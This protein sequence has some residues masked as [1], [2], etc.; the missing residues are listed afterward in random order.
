LG[1]RSH[2]LTS[3]QIID[4]VVGF[5]VDVVNA[6]SSTSEGSVYP[7]GVLVVVS[8]NPLQRSLEPLILLGEEV[9]LVEESVEFCVILG[10][11]VGGRLDR[12]GGRPEYGGNIVDGVE[13]VR[14]DVEECSGGLGWFWSFEDGVLQGTRHRGHELWVELLRRYGTGGVLD[15]SGVGV[16]RWA[17]VREEGYMAEMGSFAGVKHRALVL[18]RVSIRRIIYGLEWSGK[19]LGFRF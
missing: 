19:W 10:A 17:N 2:G 11:F 12:D 6:K 8:G 16:Y 7:A 13:E 1:S 3:V 14:E 9:L 5:V 15:Y 4:P 18:G